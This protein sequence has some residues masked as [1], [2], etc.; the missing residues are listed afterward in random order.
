MAMR[1]ISKYMDPNYSGPPTDVTFLFK[2]AGVS[3]KEVK[4]HKKILAFASDVFNREFYGGMESEDEITIKDASQEVFQVMVDFIHNKQP[5]WKDCDLSFLASLYYLADKYNIEE[6]RDKIIASIPEQEVTKDNVLGVAILAEDNILLQPLSET[7]YDVAA[8]FMKKDFDGKLENA[9]DIFTE[10]NEK[11]ALVI[12]KVME[13][14]K[15]LKSPT[16]EHCKQFSC[17]NGQGVTHQNFVAGATVR[18]IHGKGYPG[19]NKLIKIVNELSFTGRKEDGTEITGLTLD[20]AYYEYKCF[21][22]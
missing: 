3:T 14:V 2:E 7:L 15:K 21:K 22:F 12:F 8:R 17:L 6:L 16:C 19:I 5:D 18:Y 1:N 10:V 13:R 4:A 9:L 20:P 11:H